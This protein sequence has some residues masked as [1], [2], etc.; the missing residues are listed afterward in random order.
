[1]VLEISFTQYNI[2][3]VDNVDALPSH[4]DCKE[5]SL[6]QLVSAGLL[7]LLHSDSVQQPWGGLQAGRLRKIHSAGSKLRKIHRAGSKPSG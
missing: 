7:W 2:Q 3:C 5:P 6:V 1:M 4:R